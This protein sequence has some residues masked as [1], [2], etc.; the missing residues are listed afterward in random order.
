MSDFFSVVMF[1]V[2]CGLVLAFPPFGILLILLVLA[3]RL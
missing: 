2:L 3:N 1:F